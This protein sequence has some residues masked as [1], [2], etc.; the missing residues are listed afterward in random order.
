MQRLGVGARVD[1]RLESLSLGN[2]QRVQLAAAFVHDPEVLLLDEP[3]SGLDPMGVDALSE[4]LVE[5]AGAGTA[6]LF[7]SHQLDLVEQLCQDVAIISSGR[8]VAAAPIER[9]RAGERRLVRVQVSGI[10]DP[11]WAGRLAGV[12]AVDVDADE[13]LFA[14]SDA[15]DTQALLDAA[16]DAGAVR[17]FGFE[18]RSLGEIYREVV[19]E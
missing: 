7:S 1:D 4:V 16:R 12:E 18:R 9:L 3:F 15:A 11:S 6:V 14:L 2:Q 13:F 19:G 10:G 5:R 8:L 17:H